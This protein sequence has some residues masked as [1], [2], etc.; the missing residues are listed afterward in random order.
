MLEDSEGNTRQFELYENISEFIFNF[1]ESKR[2]KKEEKIKGLEKFVEPD[3]TP[4]PDA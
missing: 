1:E 2:K 4:T 3:V